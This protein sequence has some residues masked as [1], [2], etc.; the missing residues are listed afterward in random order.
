MEVETTA[1]RPGTGA[2]ELAEL[3]S[4]GSRSTRASLSAWRISQQSPFRKRSLWT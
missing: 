2:E 1:E 3:L 4:S